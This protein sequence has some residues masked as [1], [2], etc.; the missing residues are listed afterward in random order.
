MRKLL[1]PEQKEAR[2]AYEKVW[3]A[4][5][6]QKAA[7]YQKQYKIDNP[8]CNKKYTKLYR[9]RNPDKAKESSKKYKTNNK[10]KITA[11]RIAYKARK[12]EL[13][14]I[15]RATDPLFNLKSSIR[16]GVIKSFYR[17]N[18]RKNNKTEE[19]LGCT[20]QELKIHLEALFQP[21]MTWTNYGKYN[22][23]ECFG[24]DI[25]HI[26]PLSSAKS[27]EDIIKL[28]HYSNLQPL[29]SKINR[30]IKRDNPSYY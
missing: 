13:L 19:I 1:T 16:G 10:D 24:W 29:C 27:E 8:D 14:K 23:T 11:A 22:G 30:D 28:N 25:D 20:Y 7:E 17:I 4:A 18:A 6:K 26:I 21:W 2:K 12:N 3:R 9:E 5:N 15:K